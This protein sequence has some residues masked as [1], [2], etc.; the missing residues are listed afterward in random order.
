M[1]AKEYAIRF[2]LAKKKDDEL[3]NILSD[4][5]KE[6][7]ALLDSRKAKCD[8]AVIAVFR[9]LDQKFQAFVR[10]VKKD[11]LPNDF[12]WFRKAVKIG[13]PQSAQQIFC[14]LGWDYDHP[15]MQINP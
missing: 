12:L 4:M 1:K 6:A 13:F 3:A 15:F 8:D 11:L 14:H 2:T 5:I 7:H 9:E 10:I